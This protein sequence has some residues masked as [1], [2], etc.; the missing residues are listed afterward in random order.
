MHEG[1][2]QLPYDYQKNPPCG[3]LISRLS[4]NQCSVPLLCE[5][6]VPQ[7]D[8]DCGHEGLAPVFL[9]SKSPY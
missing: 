7:G 1:T 5:S 9:S 6:I 3:G 4:C 8:R 2:V